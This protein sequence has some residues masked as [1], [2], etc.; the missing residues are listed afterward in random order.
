VRLDKTKHQTY[1]RE[2]PLASA[3]VQA[4]LSDKHNLVLYVDQELVEKSR[5][6]GVNLSKLFENH[7]KHLLTQFSTVYTENNFESADKKFSWW[8]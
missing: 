2:L 5:E 7:L 6:L 4:Q 1:S 8:G 3:R